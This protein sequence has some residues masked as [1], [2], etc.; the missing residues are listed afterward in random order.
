MKLLVR[1]ASQRS[2]SP[3]L[4]PQQ[5]SAAEEPSPAF[6][7]RGRHPLLT[8]AAHPSG[9][10]LALH[11]SSIAEQARRLIGSNWVEELVLKGTPSPADLEEIVAVAR[12][13]GRALRVRATL[14]AGQLPPARAG[15]SWQAVSDGWVLI[16]PASKRRGGTCKRAIDLIGAVSLLF[17]LTP[18]LLA[19]AIAVRASSAGPVLYRWRVLG[20]YGRPVTSYKFRTMCV[21]ADQMKTELLDCNEMSGPCFKIASDPRVTPLGRLLRRYSLD[22]LPQLWSVLRGDLSLVGPRPPSRTEYQQFELWQMRKL[23][24]RPGLTCIWQVSGRNRI[25]RF[26]DWAQLDLEYIDRWSHRLD[27]RILARTMVVV[28]QG[29]GC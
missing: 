16:P 6:E 21:G 11:G 3:A 24:V 8:L 17:L 27:L 5:Q 12:A 25:S 20:R 28:L 22:E 2:G 10:I 13:T 14:D 1:P 19:I 29:T 9:P 7:W 18:L 15:Q 23:A 4:L 26:A